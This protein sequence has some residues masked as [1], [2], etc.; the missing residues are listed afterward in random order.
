MRGERF[1]RRAL[2]FDLA[3]LG[4]DAAHMADAAELIQIVDVMP[5]R[6]GDLAGALCGAAAGSC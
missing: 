1:V 6:V 3:Q 4:L 2:G 5:R